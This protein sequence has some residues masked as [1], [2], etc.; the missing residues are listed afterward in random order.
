LKENDYLLLLAGK[1]LKHLMEA[2]VKRLAINLSIF[3]VQGLA[4]GFW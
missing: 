1:H 3:H 2:F 4:G